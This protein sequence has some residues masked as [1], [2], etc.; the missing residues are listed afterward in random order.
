MKQLTSET[1]LRD[2][3]LAIPSVACSEY[4]RTSHQASPPEDLARLPLAETQ[5]L[6]GAC[7]S[8]CQS[9]GLYCWPLGDL[10]H[11]NFGKVYNL[12]KPYVQAPQSLLILSTV[13]S[14][15]LFPFTLATAP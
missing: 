10:E 12:A 9:L 2:Q 8:H 14:N 13:D 1:E 6:L 15:G 7:S 5:T 3:H 11:P 4:Q